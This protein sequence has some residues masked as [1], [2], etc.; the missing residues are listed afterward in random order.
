MEFKFEDFIPV[1]PQQDDEDIQ[2]KLGTKA[3]FLEVKSIYNEASPSLGNLYKHQEAFK[4]Y[5]IQYDRMLNI[6]SVGTGKTCALVAVVEYM[7]KNPY[8]KKAYVLE[9][10]DNTKEEFKKQIATKCTKDVYLS[11]KY[12][13]AKDE[14]QK[15][16]ALTRAVGETYKI[17][18]YGDLV[19]EVKRNGTSPEDIEKNYSGCIF[20]VDEAH[21]LLESSEKVNKK[22]GDTIDQDPDELQKDPKDKYNILWKLFHNVKRS[23][24]ILATATPMI[25]EVKEIAKIMNLILPIDQ[26]MPIDWDY[27]K[28]TLQ[29]LE[30]FFRG[31]VS[32][33]RSLDTG[34]IEEFQGNFL[35]TE[36]QIEFADEDQEVPFVAAI[37]DLEG[38][39]II[40]PKRPDVKTSIK[41]YKSQNIIFPLL[42]S[43][44]QKEGYIKSIQ[45]EKG[46]K[47]SA[48]RQDER[49]ASCLVFPDGSF[50]GQFDSDVKLFNKAGK[51]IEKVGKDYKIT[52]EFRRNF[53]TLDDVRKYSVKYAFIL[54]KELEA[55]RRRESGEIVGNAFCYN[56]FKTGSGLIVLSK[57]LEEVAGF[58]KFNESSSV[59]YK[60]RFGNR[61][62]RRDFEKK[63]RYGIITSG[64]ENVEIDSLLEIFKSKENYNGDYCQL[65]I[66]SES[67]RDGINLANV[68]RGYLTVAGWNQSGTVQALGRFVRATSHDI[69]LEEIKKKLES[70]GKDTYDVKA[71]IEIYKLASILDNN[72]LKKT[73]TVTSDDKFN[74][75]NKEVGSTVDLDLYALS[76]R[77]DISIRRMMKFLKQCAIDCS[78][79]YKRNIRKED[80]DGSIKCDYGECK[81][82][83]Y[84]SD[85]TQDV[86]IEETD[87]STYDILYSDEIVKQCQNEIR[88]IISKKSSVSVIDL[89]KYKDLSLY[90]PR[91][92]NLAIDYLIKEKIRI[93]NRFGFPAFIN[94]D[95]NAIFTQN[96]LPTYSENNNNMA[97]INIYKDMMFG[98]Y[99][100]KFNDVINLISN[101]D[102]ED[103][104]NGIITMG[105]ITDDNFEEFSAK[106]DKMK[107]DIKIDILE[108]SIIKRINMELGYN[109]HEEKMKLPE[110]VV[111]GVMRKYKNFIYT[112]SEPLED[113]IKIKNHLET[114]GDRRG[115]TR[116][117][118]ACP[119]INSLTMKG[120]DKGTELVYLH[121]ASSFKIEVTSF[122]VNTQFMNPSEDIRIFKASE[123]EGW[124]NIY[125]Y[126]CQ[127][128]KNV[129]LKENQKILKTFK[130][131]F[132]Y[133]GTIA[134]DKKFRIISS[135]D[136][137]LDTND[138][139]S[140][141]KG[142]ECNSFKEKFD[143]IEILKESNYI[144]DI[145]GDLDLP[146]ETREE[147]EDY[148][149]NIEKINRTPKELSIYTD[150]DLL[151]F[152]KWFFAKKLA[153]KRE[154]CEY[155]KEL[156][157]K[158][159]R[160]YY[161]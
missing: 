20:I 57:L 132:N 138:Q 139:R 45:E 7:K 50:G 89:Y 143:L 149:F 93:K 51:Y 134:Q 67:A 152:A 25:N 119:V 156:F 64:M 145:I 48:F 22:T 26:Q 148:L 144:P 33:V 108:E 49:Q 5:L 39:E 127:A 158:E 87:Y 116:K 77:K 75:Y 54:E 62:I 129:I 115:R 118:K 58:E 19:N 17:M 42:M 66:G 56:E 52:N 24:V 155:I 6:H 95:G 126:E 151:F 83:C 38:N 130:D 92:I 71:R 110:S 153:N 84:S 128:Y 16:S 120:Q 70:E 29:Q 27:D 112:V 32:Y 8:F 111:L 13:E 137:N 161:V 78:I 147:L 141:S 125:D 34:V 86:S 61:S 142:T 133:F 18:S 21:N 123:N 28:V 69:I 55:V 59:F 15:R 140:I 150:K 47:S 104:L 100:N 30:P 98:F 91:Y 82:T 90:K 60:D 107:E 106:Y 31:R 12:K 109:L 99:K 65:I 73:R 136:L 43:P 76:D 36:Y 4:R 11:D 46:K 101:G 113:I 14:V 44:F 159:N 81:Y 131:K 124:R 23:K 122:R 103:V 85:L 53:R 68:L 35:N 135:K 154:I 79:N 96:E 114:S 160:I 3:E 94:T 105:E 40:S 63:P 157:E 97:S 146:Y 1:Y 9:K 41:T 88:K 74:K 72:E 10:G 80:K 2:Y 121:T 102:E 37:K 117:A